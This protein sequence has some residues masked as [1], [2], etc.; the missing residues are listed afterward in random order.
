MSKETKEL[1]CSRPKLKVIPRGIYC[2]GC[3]YGI[4]T[5][6]LCEVIEELGIEDIVIG[7]VSASCTANLSVDVGIDFM[8]AAHG[9]AAAS[10]SA[11]KRVHPGA[12]VFTIQ[13][14]GDLGSIGLGH[15]MHALL[16]GEKLTTIFLNNAAY[17]QTGGQM[18]PT[19]LLGMR[20]T[21]TPLGRSS[22]TSGFP[23]HV[24]ELAA[25][26]KGTAYSAR[27]TV[28]TPANRQ[29]AKTAIKLAFHKQMDGIGFG[30]VELISA[31][32]TNWGL[33]PVESL[34]FI[35]ERMLAEYPLGE[36]KNVDSIE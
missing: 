6:L 1:V 2:A 21:T 12:V 10:A 23:L 27:W 13:G 9:R 20:T 4:I 36:F 3:H 11:I 24:A 7:V 18:A 28:H 29:R 32:P 34:K 26:M 17:G 5:R 15:F 30:L 14:D 19:T 35:D 31:C 25:F 8:L 33:T 22:E 16:R